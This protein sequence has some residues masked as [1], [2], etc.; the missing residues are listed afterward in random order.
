MV[1]SAGIRYRLEDRTTENS[2]RESE[3]VSVIVPVY[4]VKEYVREALDSLAA[5]RYRNLEIL[6]VDDGSTDGSGEICDEYAQADTRFRVIHQENRGLSGAR[7]TALDI[8]TG[9]LV[10]FLDPDDAYDPE[11]VGKLVEVRKREQADLALCRYAVCRTTDRMNLSAA[12]TKIRP[13][14][15]P[16]SYSREEALR[17]L[18]DRKINIS[19]WNKIYRR[20]LWEGIRFPAGQVFEDM[21]TTYRILNR[22]E[23]LYVLDEILCLHRIHHGSITM[24]FSEKNIRD[25]LLAF[26]MRDSYV[27]EQIRDVFSG[28]QLFRMK[29]SCLESMMRMY[30]CYCPA[31]ASGKQ[32]D[33]ELRQRIIGARRSISLRRCRFR[34]RVFYRMF[35][36]CPGFTRMTYPLYLMLGRGKRYLLNR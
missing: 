8:M 12:R 4:N 27:R 15:L 20:E 5:Q 10:M 28:E 23:K 33:A 31:G 32:F 2:V 7:N 36:F 30:F 9:D 26:S 34:T 16:G 25:H 18:A 14:G 17:A 11:T 35:R 24:T 1:Y 29:Q 3:R 6:V 21:P 22:T 19:V 13:S